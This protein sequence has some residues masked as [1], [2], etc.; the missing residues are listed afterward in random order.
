[1]DEENP[2]V[3]P[4]RRTLGAA[5]ALIG[6]GTALL[7]AA[8]AGAVALSV[9]SRTSMARTRNEAAPSIM[10][11]EAPAPS[12]DWKR[13]G[14]SVQG[15]PILMASFGTGGRRVLVIGGIHGSEFGADVAEQFATWLTAHPGATPT[16]TRVDVVAC[17]N[18]DGRAAGTKGNAHAVNLN[19]NF[20]TRNW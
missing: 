7:V 17:A 2:T 6:V 3:D 4:H 8:A 5:I 13:V 20:P 11:P 12:V 19:G 9:T 16:G 15:R 14:F 18:P 1:M 10:L